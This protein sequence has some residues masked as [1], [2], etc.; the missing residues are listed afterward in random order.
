[1]YYIAVTKDDGTVVY[2]IAGK[3]GQLNTTESG[4]TTVAPKEG[5][6]VTSLPADCRKVKLNGLTYFVSVDGIYYQETKDSNGNTVYKVVG[7]DADGDK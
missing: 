1:V 5:D 6:I 3:D 4:A 7:L 2:E